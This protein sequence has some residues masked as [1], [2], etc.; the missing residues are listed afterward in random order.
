MFVNN[1][2]TDNMTW[3]L[4]SAYKKT[5]APIWK[6]LEKHVLSSR[7]KRREI[8]VGKLSLIT[9]D[10]EV[11]FIPGKLL[12]NGNIGHKLTVSAFSFSRSA[13]EKILR[14]GGRVILLDEFVDSYPDGKGVR[15]LG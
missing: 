6:S 4:R 11:V 15:I 9:K 14:S 1:T 10:N 8:N 5:K 7:S 12:G 3:I 13:A 2:L